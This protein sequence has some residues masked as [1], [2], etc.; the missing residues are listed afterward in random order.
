LFAARF[1]GRVKDALEPLNI[2]GLCDNSKQNWY[3]V[4]LED[5][6]AGAEKFGKSKAEITSILQNAVWAQVTGAGR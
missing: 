4:N 2:A 5:V 1:A 6:I 3:G